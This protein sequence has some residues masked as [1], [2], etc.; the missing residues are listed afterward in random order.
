MESGTYFL[1]CW[2]G[3]L[4]RKEFDL[5]TDIPLLYPFNWPESPLM[6][7]LRGWMSMSVMVDG[8]TIG[9]LLSVSWSGMMM[10]IH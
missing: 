3:L 7:V 2:G 9:F 5:A 8:S 6:I 10:P 1:L 4:C